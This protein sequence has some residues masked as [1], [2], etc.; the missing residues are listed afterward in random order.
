M[1]DN[2][3]IILVLCLIAAIYAAFKVYKSER[4]EPGEVGTDTDAPNSNDM[5]NLTAHPNFSISELACKDAARTPV[6]AQY[7]SNATT[8]LLNLQVLRNELGVPIFINSGYR[9]PAHNANVGGKSN[10]AHLRAMAADIK[11]LGLSPRTVKAT[12]ERLIS[13]GRMLQGGIGLYSSF[14]HYDIRG[15]KARW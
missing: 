13:E 15:Y 12:I 5:E 14:V 7:L 3:L 6:P 8:L 2:K 1:Q 9:T 11:A 10:S 4:S